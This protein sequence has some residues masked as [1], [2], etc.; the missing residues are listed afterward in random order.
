MRNRILAAA[1]LLAC[2][3]ALRAAA[4]ELLPDRARPLGQ[5]WCPPG[6]PVTRG[7]DGVFHD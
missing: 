7:H 6:P 1:V 3:F 4:A 2:A 5:P